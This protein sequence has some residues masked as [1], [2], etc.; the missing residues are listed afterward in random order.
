MT[1]F[2]LSTFQPQ[3]QS[4]SGNAVRERRMAF[5]LV[6]LWPFGGLV[7]SLWKWRESWA[8]NV[9]WIACIYFGAIHIYCPEGTIL[10]IGADGGRYVLTLMKWHDEGYSIGMLINN[11]L[12]NQHIMD[13]YQQI[14]TYFV[15]RFTS[16][17]H[18]LFFFVAVV[19][20]FFYS[21]NIWYI[22]EKLPGQQLG[23]EFFILI[24]LYFL[25][26]PITFINGVRMWTALHV[27]VYALM[28]YLLE[29]DKSKLWWLVA[30]PFIHFSYLYISLLAVAYVFL[31]DYWKT[32]N[33]LVLI[34]A[35]SLFATTFFI[36][37]LNLDSLSSFLIRFSPS[38]YEG[39]I[40]QYVSQTVLERNASRL[41]LNNWYV[42]GSTK[43]LFWCCN[44]L[45]I[46][47]FTVFSKSRE[48]QEKYCRL[49]V[50]AL[51]FGALTNMM[52]LMPSGARFV[53][54]A[55]MF[56]FPVIL[57]ALATATKK[58]FFFKAVRVA[59]VFL[60]LPFV[61]NIRRLFDDYSFSLFGNFITV[62]FWED[63]V[64]L[65]TYIKW[66]V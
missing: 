13:L 6:F 61:V 22:L 57:L 4:T 12:I 3:I 58:D 53:R 24:T 21:R 20:G 31:L 14:L 46:S 56:Q 7:Y 36:N 25:V 5:F 66:L 63:N 30:V 39:R 27:Y 47:M 29:K 32:R 49:Y 37:S 43:T 26:C 40:S 44:I 19:F 65:I 1:E 59:L 10:G 16:N 15:S 48:L 11:Y 38:A 8:K 50:F 33:R 28:P 17:G 35:L 9:F 41:A 55:Q 62:F 18:V 45:M 23:R 52:A 54:V 60:L 42:A 64:P 2:A 34:F 51:F